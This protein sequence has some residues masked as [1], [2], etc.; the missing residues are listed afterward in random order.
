MIA[1]MTGFGRATV[2]RDGRSIEV[3]IRAVNHRF[4]DLSWKLPS[5]FV[6]F[7]QELSRSIREK[8]SRGHIDITVRESGS[9]EIEYDV[10]FRESAFRG[11][12]GLL[13]GATGL[14]SEALKLELLRRREILDFLP[15]TE[16]GSSTGG[17]QE[18]VS[19][20]LEKAVAEL[21]LMRE[22]EGA[23]LEKIL[24]DGL[25]ELRSLLA[26]VGDLSKTGLEEYRTKL[27]ARIASYVPEI[28]GGRIAAEAAIFADRSDISEEL[29]RAESHVKQFADMLQ[30]GG[31]VGRK[32][33]FLLQELNREVNTLGTKAQSSEIAS[34]VISAKGVLEKLR[35]Q[36]LNVE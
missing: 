27:Q 10:A 3:E 6:S 31:A 5:R 8:L 35:E 13:E 33:E 15:R 17:D 19:D 22:R 4:L 9:V 28:D 34:I 1:S 23:H 16:G 14:S 30:S 32:L 18:L 20:A 29:A 2:T 7:E 25:K 36:V 24:S 11:A 12:L 26:P 21:L